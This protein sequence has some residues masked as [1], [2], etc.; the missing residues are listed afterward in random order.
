MRDPDGFTVGVAIGRRR[1]GG[2]WPLIEWRP[3]AVLAAVPAAPLWNVLEESE[4]ETLFYA[5]SAFVTLERRSTLHYGD[6]L[7]AAVPSL[8]VVLRPDGDR[9][10]ILDV[11]VD[12]YEGEGYMEGMDTIVEAVPMPPVVA[13]R[14]QDFYD[15][16]H[17]ETVFVKRE[18]DAPELDVFGRG[19][20][21]RRGDR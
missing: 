1:I 5:G 16:C 11:T 4:D 8:W 20:R 12:P 18:R 21:D 10:A 3:R 17:V 6:N 14:V 13:A 15:R 2:R 7:V 19:Q 9:V